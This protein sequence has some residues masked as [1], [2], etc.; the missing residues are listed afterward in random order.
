MELSF[1]DVNWLSVLVAT[2]AAFVIGSVWYSPVLFGKIWQRE[3]RLSD[4]EIQNTNMGVI[5]GLAFILNLIGVIF[6]DLLIGPNSTVGSGLIL[7]LVVGVVWVSSAMG[8]NY[9]FSR[10]SFKL[11]AI[12]A[13]YFVFFYALVGVILGEW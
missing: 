7:G 11:F 10:K 13:G 1:Q 9:L 12:D 6:L 8:I 5:F 3:I 4:Q 2:V